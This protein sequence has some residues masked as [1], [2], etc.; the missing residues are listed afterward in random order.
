M[1]LYRVQMG[2]EPDDT[3]DKFVLGTN[4]SV[5]RVAKGMSWSKIVVMTKGGMA[6]MHLP[7]QIDSQDVNFY[8]CDESE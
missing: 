7:K 3:L 1:N 6:Q 2:N 8:E 4:E 5:M